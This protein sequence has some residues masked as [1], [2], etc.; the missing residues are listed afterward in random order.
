MLTVERRERIRRAYYIEGKHMRQIGAELRHSYWTI[1]AALDSAAVR[2]Y[3]L[4]VAK[5][6]PVLGEYKGQI[7]ALLPKSERQ[8]RKQRYTSHKIY[9]LLQK[10]GYQGSESGVRRYIGEQ[11]RALKRPPV[12]S[13]SS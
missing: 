7:E 2:S 8:P 4:T 12:Y 3:Q 10:E 13:L 6:A 9:Q 1:R 11:R 5:P